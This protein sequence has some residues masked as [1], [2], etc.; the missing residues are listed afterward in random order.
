MIPTL[1]ALAGLTATALVPL[2][3][4][5]RPATS[6]GGSAACDA[7]FHG[8]GLDAYGLTA[9]QRLVCFDTEN[10][11]GAVTIAVLDGFDGDSRLVGIDYRP[12]D[13][14]LYGLGDHGGVYTLDVDSATVS[15]VSR[16]SVPLEGA[17]FD[18]DFNPTV[19]R[20]R[21]VS[22]SGQ[23][24]RANV[25]DGMTTVDGALNTVG[26]PVVSPI[27][28]VS[29]AAYTNNDADTATATTLFDISSTTDQVVIQAPANSGSLNP[30][31][32]LGVNASGG[33][34]FDIYA[35]LDGSTAVGNEGF[36]VFSS[37]RAS[38]LYGVDLL[39]GRASE[40]G[41]FPRQVV[42]LAIPPAQG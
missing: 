36:S 30:T 20:L 1:A 34:G 26:P 31:G 37:R 23:N 3:A 16:L 4:G 15:L 17:R 19:D 42:D 24:L 33:V 18:V 22:D 9:G 11:G 7:A 2:T 12:A 29:G 28:G 5:A 38:R 27:T 25:D 13:G 21:I 6:I 40:V 35:F 39:T 10:P 32:T 8:G 14:V 41:A